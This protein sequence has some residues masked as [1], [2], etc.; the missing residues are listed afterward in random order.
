M[1]CVITISSRHCCNMHK[2]MGI[3]SIN[4]VFQWV[5]FF[6]QDHNTYVDPAEKEAPP[7]KMDIILNRIDSI[8]AAEEH[9]A[10]QLVL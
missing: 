9:P 6:H 5:K 10:F 8:E 4:Q 2:E 1:D 7:Q 3:T